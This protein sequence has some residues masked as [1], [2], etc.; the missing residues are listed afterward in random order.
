MGNGIN[1]GHH[2]GDIWSPNLGLEQLF[3]PMNLLG[4]AGDNPEIIH[5]MKAAGLIH[6]HPRSPT[7]A[8]DF[9]KAIILSVRISDRVGEIIQYVLMKACS[10]VN[11]HWDGGLGHVR[12]CH[13][14][15]RDKAMEMYIP[16]GL[17]LLENTGILRQA[18]LE[19]AN[20]ELGNRLN[21]KDLPDS[22]TFRR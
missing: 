8:M 15:D 7:N 19:S 12:L 16:C 5:S 4:P 1:L 18:D 17:R 11:D 3:P 13:P 21:D 9:Q 14:A 22:G 6:L 2:G 20:E 10:L